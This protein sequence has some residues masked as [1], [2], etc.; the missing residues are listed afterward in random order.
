[1]P[2]AYYKV[3]LNK[4]KGKEKMIG[5][6]MKNEGSKSS[7][8]SFVVSVDSVEVLTGIDFFPLLEDSLETKLESLVLKNVWNWKNVKKKK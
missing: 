6:V 8:Q 3:I 2:N 4:H 7:L 5:F 1:V